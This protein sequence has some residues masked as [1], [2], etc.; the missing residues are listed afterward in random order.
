MTTGTFIA[1]RLVLP[2]TV[3]SSI[4]VAKGLVHWMMFAQHYNNH[5]AEPPSRGKMGMVRSILL[6]CCVMALLSQLARQ[7]FRTTKSWMTRFDNL[8]MTLRTCP[9]SVKGNLEFGMLHLQPEQIGPKL[10]P[11]TAIRYFDKALMRNNNF[12]QVNFYKAL[13]HQHLNEWEL[14]EKHMAKAIPCEETMHYAIQYWQNYWNM[15]F[16][17]QHAHVGNNQAVKEFL[18]QNFQ[19]QMEAIQRDLVVAVEDWNA[20]ID[21]VQ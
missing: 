10:Q 6:V 2:C 1:D 18:K 12:C 20:H 3:A 8:S 14:Y 4:F 17:Q 7:T 16:S 5:R 19:V 21:N 15:Q 11:A 9:N 13:A